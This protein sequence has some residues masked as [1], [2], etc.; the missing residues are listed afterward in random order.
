MKYLT[1]WALLCILFGCG[2]TSQEEP[3]KKPSKIIFGYLQYEQLPE[4]QIPWDQLTHLSIAF[5]RTTEE[6][7][8]ADAANIEK[9]LPIFREGQKKGVKVLLSAGGGGNKTIMAGVLLNDTYRNRFKKELLKAVEDWGF[10][11]LDIDY[12]HWAGGPEGY[13]EGD[14]EK[15]ALL[16]NFYKE[17]RTELPKGKLLTAAVS[18]DYPEW[19]GGWGN[20]NVYTNSMFEYLDLVNIMVYDFTGGWKSS[21]VA[22]HASMEHFRM[23][24]KRWSEIR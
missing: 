10:D 17:L 19:N 22:Q 13:G 9:L 15:V 3:P 8:L 14:K 24:A 21:K 1:L 16:E 2:G 23:A 18:A 5:G 4:Y 11:G 6:G 12:E 20:Y 7:G